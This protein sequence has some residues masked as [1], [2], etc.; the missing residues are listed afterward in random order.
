MFTEDDPI[1]P[2]NSIPFKTLQNNP[3][4]VTVVTQNGGHL[5]FF[6]GIIIPQRIVDQPI[7]TFFKTVEILKDTSNCNCEGKLVC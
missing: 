1:I 5:G 7:R 3:N 2:I 4:T 6:G